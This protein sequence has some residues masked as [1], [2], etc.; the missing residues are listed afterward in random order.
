LVSRVL[1]LAQL[2][3]SLASP[4][5]LNLNLHIRCLVSRVLRL[6]QLTLSLA[7]RGVDNFDIIGVILHSNRP[8]GCE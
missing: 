7:R 8:V 1:R 4:P 2:T 6:A 5:G 3:L